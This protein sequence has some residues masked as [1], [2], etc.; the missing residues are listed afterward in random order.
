MG[1]KAFFQCL[2]SRMAP[3]ARSDSAFAPGGAGEKNKLLFTDP[4]HLTLFTGRSK[5]GGEVYTF[6]RGFENPPVHPLPS[7]PSKTF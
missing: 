5:I 7:L 6:I 4:T 3:I 1:R 2:R